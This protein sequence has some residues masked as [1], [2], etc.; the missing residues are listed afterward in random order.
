[1]EQLHAKLYDFG[2]VE[3]DEVD[4]Q[5]FGIGDWKLNQLKTLGFICATPLS[6]SI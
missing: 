3:E 4:H 2:R 1:M 5:P 6:L